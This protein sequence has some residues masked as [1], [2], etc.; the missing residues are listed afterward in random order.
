M[1]WPEESVA[2]RFWIFLF[3]TSS[4]PLLYVILG[5]GGGGREGEDKKK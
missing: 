5:G 1:A 2:R 4:I 3:S